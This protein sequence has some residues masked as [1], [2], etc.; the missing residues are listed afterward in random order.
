MVS[1]KILQYWDR[2][3]ATTELDMMD[4]YIATLSCLGRV[5]RDAH[6]RNK[7]GAFISNSTRLLHTILVP[8]PDSVTMAR[9]FEY[10]RKRHC[11]ATTTATMTKHWEY[12]QGHRRQRSEIPPMQCSMPKMLLVAMNQEPWTGM[13][14]DW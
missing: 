2:D 10:C 13:Q 14:V 9:G 11:Q 6:P 8:I 5:S 3:V 12:R 4:L 7:I 1:P